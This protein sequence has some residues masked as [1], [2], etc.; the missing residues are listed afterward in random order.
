MDT[1]NTWG[2][3]KLGHKKDVADERKRRGQAF[4]KRERGVKKT[5]AE[6][7]AEDAD[8]EDVSQRMYR[9]ILKACQDRLDAVCV[10]GAG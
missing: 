5:Q 2:K 8:F 3:K 9:D 10:K 1:K 4:G 7:E 6:M